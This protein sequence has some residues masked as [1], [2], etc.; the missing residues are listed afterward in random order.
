MSAILALL[1]VPLA[2]P[3]HADASPD[4]IPEA[5]GQT[6]DG[7]D[8]RIGRTLARTSD[9]TRHAITYRSGGLTISGIMNLPHGRGPFPVIV[10]AHGYID[11]RVYVSGQGFRREQDALARNGYA[12]LHVDYRN[13]AGS[14]DDSSNGVAVRLGYAQDVI[15]AARAVQTA[16]LPE[17]DA[18]RI[19]LLGRSMGGSVAFNALVMRPGTFDAVVTYASTSPD[20]VDSFNRWQRLDRKASR[21]IVMRYGDPDVDRRGWAE[22][23]TTNYFDRITEPVLMFHGT[24]DESCLRTIRSTVQQEAPHA[25]A[26][27]GL[28]AFF[29]SLAE[30]IGRDD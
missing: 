12:V 25:R 3:A 21:E 14:D 22:V 26:M 8:L 4:S 5:I 13:H 1:G 18:S 10:L 7:R 17:L 29:S 11:P 19:G 20:P 6:Y 23:T 30:R 15:N 27:P 28:P 16:R 24:S 2:G 9:Y